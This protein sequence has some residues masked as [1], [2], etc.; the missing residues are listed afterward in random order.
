M[1]VGGELTETVYSIHLMWDERVGIEPVI[2]GIA[3]G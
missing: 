2:D 3:K 1:D